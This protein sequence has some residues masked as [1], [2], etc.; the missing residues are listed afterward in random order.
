MCITNYI[1]PNVNKFVSWPFC[2][3]GPRDPRDSVS[4]RYIYNFNIFSRII[5]IDLNVIKLLNELFELLMMKTSKDAYHAGTTH[6]VAAGM[7]H[8]LCTVN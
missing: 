3:D 8:L 1:V 7:F 6:F 2:P 4:L 5:L